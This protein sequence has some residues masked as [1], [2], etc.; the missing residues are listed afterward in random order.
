[1]NYKKY[2]IFEQKEL[3]GQEWLLFLVTVF[4]IPIPKQK[5]TNIS[6]LCNKKLNKSE[7]WVDTILI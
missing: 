3:F 6:A 4:P 7:V 2:Y 5:T 1:M